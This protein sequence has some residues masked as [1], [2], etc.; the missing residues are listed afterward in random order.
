MDGVSSVPY[1][2]AHFACLARVA[3]WQPSL[4]ANTSRGKLG[5]RP[6][7]RQGSRPGFEIVSGCM[8]VST[9]REVLQHAT[10]FVS[11]S[12]GYVDG[13][14]ER[15]RVHEWHLRARSHGRI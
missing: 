9:A 4:E 12:V 10:T 6:R 5:K 11:C 14:K 1:L 15:H 8:K 2:P 13:R 3:L 7:T